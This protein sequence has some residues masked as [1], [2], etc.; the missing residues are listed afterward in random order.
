VKDERLNE[1][2][3]T[4][5][6]RAK[7]ELVLGRPD[8]AF[9]DTIGIINLARASQ[10]GNPEERSVLIG[11][12]L[13]FTATEV[14]KE[15]CRRRAWNDSQFAGF[16]QQ[17]PDALFFMKL[18]RSFQFGRIV[19][20]QFLDAP[21][22]PANG[23]F[24]P[25]LPWWLFHG[26]RQQNKVMLAQGL[27]AVSATF[28][29]RT[30]RVFPERL[31]P[32]KNKF[33][34][35]LY[36]FLYLLSPLTWVNSR[37]MELPIELKVVANYGAAQNSLAEAVTACA[38]ERHRLAHGNYPATLAELVPAFL[39]TVPVDVFTGQPLG[40]IRT[41]DGGFKLTSLPSPERID[42]PVAWV[43]AGTP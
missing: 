8:D 29:P 14:F 23:P 33:D 20:D 22:A 17:L 30:D 37:L 9:A 31:Q 10:A 27:A 41:P 4:L 13:R 36:R 2:G 32:L 35:Y 15:G 16:Q 38:L 25:K 12:A 19:M 39:A 21:S 42:D 3:E 11:A 5:G 34:D 43:Q 1:L 18:E 28:D 26:W 7:V 24:D 6:V 40:Y